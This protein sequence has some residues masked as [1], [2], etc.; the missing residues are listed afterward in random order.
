MNTIDTYVRAR[1]DTDTKACDTD[2]LVPNKKTSQAIVELEAGGGKRFNSI[3]DLM[4]DLYDD[5]KD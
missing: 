5:E 3:E 2:A 1:I 4:A